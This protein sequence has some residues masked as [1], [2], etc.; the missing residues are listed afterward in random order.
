M[1][2]S[3]NVLPGYKQTCKT[4]NASIQA[5]TARGPGRQR[6]CAVLKDSSEFDREPMLTRR[7][8]ETR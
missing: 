5:E 4:K 3:R 6:L 2:P 8:A 7:R 1:L